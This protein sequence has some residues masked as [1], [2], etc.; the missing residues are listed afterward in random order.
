MTMAK[1]TL[2]ESL[3]DLLTGIETDTGDP[4]RERKAA[5]LRQALDILRET[6]GMVTLRLPAYAVRYLSGMCRAEHKRVAGLVSRDVPYTLCADAT[7]DSIDAIYSA[8][9]SEFDTGTAAAPPMPTRGWGSWRQDW[10]ALLSA[11]LRRIFPSLR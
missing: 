10:H 9:P 3:E 7:F 4:D 5:A 1:T 8:I 2:I 11:S 6:D